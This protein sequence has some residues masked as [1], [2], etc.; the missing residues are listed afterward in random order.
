MDAAPLT[1]FTI[2]CKKFADVFSWSE[3][4]HDPP[5]IC[6]QLF[7]LHTMHNCFSWYEQVRVVLGLSSHYFLS[8]F[9]FFFF[10]YLFFSRSISI[11]IDTVWAQLFLEFSTIHF[12]T[13]HICSTWSED[14]SAVLG[15]SSHHTDLK[16]I[17][18]F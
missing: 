1:V 15:F 3:D 6:N 4:V 11:R 7:F 17:T 5:I 18:L 13:M 16:V 8:T 12:K 10:F 9:F 14:V 2:F